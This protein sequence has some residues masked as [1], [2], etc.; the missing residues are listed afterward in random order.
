MPDPS[1]EFA[2]G[3]AVEIA[4]AMLTLLRGD[5]D[6]FA[7]FDTGGGGIDDYEIDDFLTEGTYQTPFLAVMLGFTIE[8]AQGSNKQ[9]RLQTGLELGIVLRQ[10]DARGTNVW[11]RSRI[12]EH[13]KRLILSNDGILQDG[14]GND[15]TEALTSFERIAKPLQLRDPSKSLMTRVTAVFESQIK[16]NTGEF[17]A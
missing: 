10:E 9:A 4:E 12:A 5:A 11:I 1:P 15:L 3:V 7:Y 8:A 16:W 13:I 6:L 14:G 17:I 2:R